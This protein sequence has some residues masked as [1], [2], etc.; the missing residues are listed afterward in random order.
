M[1][2]NNL[3]IESQLELLAQS[4]AK[5]LQNKRFKSL[6]EYKIHSRLLRRWC[7]IFGQKNMD[8]ECGK[9]FRKN[10]LRKMK[11]SFE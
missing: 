6:H 8:S 10:R 5:F 1:N 7:F 11:E 9:H 2:K 4:S 3:Y